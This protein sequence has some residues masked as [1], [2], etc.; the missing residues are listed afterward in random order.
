MSPIFEFPHLSLAV[1]GATSF[2]L[3]MLIVFTKQWHG[4]LSLDSTEGIQKFH[5][6]PT[7]RIGG[8]AI[9]ISACTGMLV[10]PDPVYS[11]LEPMLISALPVFVLGIAEDITKKV[12]ITERLLAGLASGVLGWWL[13]GA[14][15]NRVDVW[16]L[17]ILLTV[18]P[19][20][21]AFTAFAVAGIANAVNMID[22][23][24]GLAA[25]VVLIML[26]ALGVIAYVA[27]D[28]ILA[29]VCVI[30]AG[31]VA[32]FFLLNFP[33]GKIFMGD[34][35]AYFLGFCVAWLAVLLAARNS[36]VSP[37]AGL[38]ACSYPVIEVLFSVI[39]R[40]SRSMN[41]S[42]PDRL[43][44]HTLVKYRV[45]R[46]RFPNAHATLKNA[47]VSPVIWGYAMVPALAAVVLARSTPSLIAAFI[48]AVLAYRWQYRRLVN[49][50]S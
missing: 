46:K 11:V 49:F 13:T 26:S 1:G 6:S 20:S 43:H 17:D 42:H 4:R 40:H 37:W 30:F 41:V 12:G 50:G 24:N 29:K 32:G 31:V 8:L 34:G 9:F 44:L 10:A 48:I 16:G 5:S 38:V 23:F 45:A 27:G 22:G 36:N 39:R 2:V 19:F 21:V 35:G 7:P 33:Y 28:P 15:L 47:S 25:G 3:C 18:A 14:S